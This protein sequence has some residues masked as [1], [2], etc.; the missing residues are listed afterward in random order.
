MAGLRATNGDGCEVT[1]TSTN[2]KKGHWKLLMQL[3]ITPLDGEQTIYFPQ[4]LAEWLGSRAY[5]P[6]F[7]KSA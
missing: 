5:S 3:P 2:A 7:V 1:N 4:R 6:R